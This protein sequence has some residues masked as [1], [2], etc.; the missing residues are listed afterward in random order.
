MES[1]LRPVPAQ[2]GLKGHIATVAVRRALAEGDL[3]SW[4]SGRSGY[5]SRAGEETSVRHQRTRRLGLDLDGTEG[6]QSVTLSRSWQRPGGRLQVLLLP[7][8]PC[9]CASEKSMPGPGQFF[10]G[11]D[12]GGRCCAVA[13]VG[14]ALH[15]EPVRTA[16]LR[17]ASSAAC[18]RK[19]TKGPVRHC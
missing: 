18:I 1:E 12:R 15:F 14:F 4:W 5:Y 19:L 16:T 8:G 2:A 10:L 3:S 6:S 9:Q 17:L 13:A 11:D 7:V